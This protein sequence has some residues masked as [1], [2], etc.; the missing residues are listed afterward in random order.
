MEF[1]DANRKYTETGGF[2]Q[3]D[4]LTDV[5]IINSLAKILEMNPE[6]IIRL[7]GHT[8][9]NEDAMLGLERAQRVKI[10][11]IERG[12]A[13]DR[14]ILEN[15]GNEVPLIPAELIKGL[16]TELER[17]VALQRNRRVVVTVER[18]LQE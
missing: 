12:I 1:A 7:V 8:A 13:G 2:T 14:M 17:D 11:L 6:L 10:E 3:S 9:D 5:V 15:R 18:T 4:T 16:P